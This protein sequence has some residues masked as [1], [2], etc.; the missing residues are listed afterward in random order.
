MEKDGFIIQTFTMNADLNEDRIRLDIVSPD[1]RL[2]A[3]HLTRRLTDRMIPAF[4]IKAEGTVQ[5]G[6]PK[7]LA[8]SMQQEALRAERDSNLLPAVPPAPDSRPYLSQ[9][10]HLSDR[11][12][13]TLWT[14]TD[15]AS[16]EAHMVLDAQALRAVLD[17]LLI[18]Y[19]ALEW[20]E[21][22]FPEW[23]R[24]RGK[25]QQVGRLAMN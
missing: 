5:P 20:S 1:G 12:D 25:V 14:Q 2:R 22:A 4:A 24:E 21:Q 7:D 11:E 3:I 6:I 10:V 16:F 9:T 13:G 17:V 23:V 15:D 19:R 18:T 8:L